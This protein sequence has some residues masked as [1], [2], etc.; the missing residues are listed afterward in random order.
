MLPIIFNPDQANLGGK[1]AFIFGGF[2]VICC[3]Y[4]W[5]Y[6]VETAGRSYEELDELF[7]KGIS[8]KEFATYVTDVQTV[9]KDVKESKAMD[10]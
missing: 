1:T 10:S 8:V 6:Q 4:V 9:S 5:F 2:G 7:Q 3:V